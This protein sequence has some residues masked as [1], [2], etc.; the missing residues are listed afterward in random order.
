MFDRYQIKRI[1]ENI[2]C[3]ALILLVGGLMMTNNIPKQ[4]ISHDVRHLFEVAAIYRRL[5][6]DTIDNKCVE[7]FTIISDNYERQAAAIMGAYG[8]SPRLFNALYMAD[9]SR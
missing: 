1:E 3:R 8:C 9:V 4:N 2:I 6:R 5:A 7:I